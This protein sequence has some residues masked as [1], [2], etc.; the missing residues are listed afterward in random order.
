M[1]ILKLI[2]MKLLLDIMVDNEYNEDVGDG[3]TNNGKGD[4]S[5]RKTFS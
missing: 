1:Y 5:R 2:L 4:T 3:D